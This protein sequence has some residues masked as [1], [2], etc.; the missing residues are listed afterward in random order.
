MAVPM[1]I[2]LIQLVISVTK[3]IL[4]LTLSYLMEMAQDQV[5]MMGTV[6]AV[7]EKEKVKGVVQAPTQ[8]MTPMRCLMIQMRTTQLG[9][10]G[11]PTIWQAELDWLCFWRLL[12][13]LLEEMQP[14]HLQ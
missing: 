4:P 2:L 9:I 6:K 11:F 12:R 10:S 3:M 1:G 14:L 8:M 5:G 7:V 13:S